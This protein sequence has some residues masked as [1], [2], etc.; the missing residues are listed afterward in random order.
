[1]ITKEKIK[2]FISNDLFW[3]CFKVVFYT[4]LLEFYFLL[5]FDKGNVYAPFLADGLYFYKLCLILELGLSFLY[6]FLVIG[7]I[8][9]YE[10]LKE[11][12][13][14]LWFWIFVLVLGLWFTTV[15]Y[16]FGIFCILGSDTGLLYRS[17]L[18]NLVTYWLFGI[19]F[20]Y[21][22][23]VYLVHKTYLIDAFNFRDIVDI[24]GYVDN[25]K[26]FDI[27][28]EQKSAINSY[29]SNEP[30]SF[31][32]YAPALS[33]YIESF[34]IITYFGEQSFLNKDFF[35]YWKL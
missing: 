11:K 15:W 2:D 34:K 30:K 6:I 25:R 13:H 10:N 17:P 31:K 12:N 23:G 32:A 29:F 19:N 4:F 7:G 28:C 33:K 9:K 16:K 22:P 14:R 18:Q 27:L 1:M 24:N 5:Y 20:H 26:Y 21:E 35:Y 8:F 3:R